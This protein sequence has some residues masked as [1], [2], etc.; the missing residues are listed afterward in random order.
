MARPIVTWQDALS[1]E[2]ITGPARTGAGAANRSIVTTA[3]PAIA[4]ASTTT[5]GGKTAAPAPAVPAAVI[6]TPPTC[7]ARNMNSVAPHG[8]TFTR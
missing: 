4:R 7:G 5:S 2:P 1:R 8:S 6:A 3:Q